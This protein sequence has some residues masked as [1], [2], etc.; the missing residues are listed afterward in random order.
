MSLKKKSVLN[1]LFRYM[2]FFGISMGFVF[3]VYA[4]FFVEWK[5]GLFIYF[6]IGCIAAGITVGIVSFWFVRQFL[7]K[8][9]LKISSVARQVAA[10]KIGVQLNIESED[11]V[12]EIANGF[13]MVLNILKELIQSTKNIANEVNSIGGKDNKAGT[14][15]YLKDTTNSVNDTTETIVIL[16]DQISKE[17]KYIQ[18]SVL[19]SSGSLKRLDDLVDRFSDMISALNEQTNKINSIV[20]FVKD[21]SSKTNILALNASIEATKAGKNGRSFAVVAGEVQN[22]SN[23]IS[24][25]VVQISRITNDLKTEL[26]TA[27]NLNEEINRLFKSNQKENI[28]FVNIV[29]KVDGFTDSNLSENQNL[30]TLV[31]NLNQ[32]V[33]IINHRFDIF[34]KSIKKLNDYVGKYQ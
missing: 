26:L 3:P 7:I 29:K 13:N 5:E 23:N 21:L 2:M 22:L 28:H 25:S 4:N 6:L 12:G 30:K 33:G 24:D 10:N 14:I 1:K 16:S 11:A 19:S 17:F 8:E 15:E 20:T 34:F 27:N 32:T 18:T 9:L 31:E